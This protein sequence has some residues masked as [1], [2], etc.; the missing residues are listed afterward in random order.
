[1]K[2]K[3]LIEIFDEA[4]R[5]YA[6]T[7][8][9]DTGYKACILLGVKII[10]DNASDSITIFCPSKSINYYVEIEEELYKLFYKKG[11]KKAVREITLSKYKDKL[12]RVKSA[13]SKEMNGNRSPKRLRILKETRE[14]ILKKYYRLCQK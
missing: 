1:M 7:Q 9:N 4:N 11:W 3:T 10:K 13:I 12:D 6:T 2:T 8:I 5:D 14:Q